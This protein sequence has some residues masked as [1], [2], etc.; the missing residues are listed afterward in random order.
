MMQ[1]DNQE[2]PKG[3]EIKKLGAVAISEKGKKPKKQSDTKNDIF[4]I[5][6][7]D[8]EA[9]EKGIIKS[10]TDGEKCVFC[11]ENDFLMVWD[12]ARSGLVG[13]GV[14]GAVGSTLV[15]I[16]L[17]NMDNHFAYY[18]LQSK[19]AELNTRAKGSG[20]PHVNP[21]L[22]WNYD[23]PIPPLPQ[24]TAIVNK[25]ESLFSEIDAGIESLKVAQNKL[26]QYRQSLLKNAFNGELTK[27][28]REE[29]ADKLPSA[30]ELLQ[31]IQQARETHYQAK[32]D[33]W[34][35]AV[36][37]WEENGKKGKKPSKP[38]K[39]S[40]ISLNRKKDI[41]RN[42]LSLNAEILC[43]FITKGTTPNKT[44]LISEKGEIPFIKVYNLTKTGVLDFSISPTFV[45]SEIHNNFLYRSKVYPN[46][47]LMNIV[48]PPLGKV[49]VVPNDYPEWNINQAIAIFRSKF[50]NSSFLANF[51]LAESTV[52]IISSQAKTT[53][54]QH[55]LTL[56]ICRKLELPIMSKEEQNQIVTI[57]E[58]Q[59]TQAD[60][61][62]QEISKQLKLAELLKQSI[63]KAAFSGKLLQGNHE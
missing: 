6:Y 9:F 7:I 30:E 41:P 52:K 59:L 62:A 40:K 19:Y 60:H 55:N 53:A 42:W 44:N 33:E 24:Q 48:G 47:V 38:I 43:D 49:S 2:L 1:M 26:A 37:I 18:F 46:D 13:K 63:L 50:Y 16:S 21:D 31:Q 32:V 3:W 51:L 27:Q 17:P 57:L 56:E 34:K 23:L 29:N 39:L 20:T 35:S 10:Y 25:I 12:G 28:W 4:T 45:T 11:D 14:K 58:K 61:F 15:R 5:P 54:G 8:I 36:Q 22:L